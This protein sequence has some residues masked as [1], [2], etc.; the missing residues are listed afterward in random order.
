MS[1]RAQL[2]TSKTFFC[3]LLRV[4]FGKTFFKKRDICLVNLSSMF[5]LTKMLVKDDKHFNEVKFIIALI[6]K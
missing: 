5:F 1:Q 4:G 3:Q 6:S 2:L